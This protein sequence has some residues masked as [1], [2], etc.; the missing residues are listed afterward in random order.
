MTTSKTTPLIFISGATAGIGL[1]CAQSFARMGWNI[2]IGARRKEKLEVIRNQ[3]QALGSADVFAHN[4]DVRSSTSVDDFGNKCLKHYG[5]CPDVIVNNAGMAAG[6]NHVK[7]LQDSEISSMLE[8]NIRGPLYTSRFFIHE[9]LEDKSRTFTV[10]NIGSIAGRTGYAGGSVYCATKHAVKAISEALRQELL[11][12]N[13]KVSNI[14]PGL[15]ETEFS[16]V[17]LQDKH[18][19]KEVYAKMTPLTAQDV[20]DTIVF[21]ATRASH[22]NIDDLLLMPTDQASVFHVHRST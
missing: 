1:A 20:A 17:R 13:I 16:E 8:T 12:T 10:I 15:V 9:M 4:L 6:T 5:Y 22:V 2:A 7:D 18:K 14:C 11:G 3:L 21:V 19:A